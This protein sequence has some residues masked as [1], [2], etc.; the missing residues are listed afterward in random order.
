MRLSNRVEG[1]ISNYQR[2]LDGYLAGVPN[3]K[4]AK[5]TNKLGGNFD[6]RIED[7]EF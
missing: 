2:I 6:G 1:L 4:L 7:L 5:A 3:E